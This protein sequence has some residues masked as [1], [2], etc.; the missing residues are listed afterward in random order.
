MRKK[1]EEEA[2][3]CELKKLKRVRK[4][5]RQKARLKKDY[6]PEGQSAAEKKRLKAVVKE[7]V[8]NMVTEEKFQNSLGK[9]EEKFQ[10]SLEKTAEK[11]QHSVDKKVSKVD[12][13]ATGAMSQVKV[14]GKSMLKDHKTLRSVQNTV[15]GVQNTVEVNYETQLQHQERIKKLERARDKEKQTRDRLTSEANETVA[16]MRAEIQGVRDMVKKSMD[17]KRLDDLIASCPDMT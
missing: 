12:Q 15:E 7:A 4:K 1:R 11:L 17:S 2:R 13:K 14:L 6:N 16:G 9:T 10:N 5:G 3:R 8:K